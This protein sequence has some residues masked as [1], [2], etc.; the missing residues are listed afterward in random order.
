M[1]LE[2]LQ[3]F[4]A[5]FQIHTSTVL[6]VIDNTS[7]LF[8]VPLCDCLHLRIKTA[9]MKNSNSKRL[10]PHC[11]FMLLA[12]AL[13]FFSYSFFSCFVHIEETDGAIVLLWIFFL[14]LF[15]QVAFSNDVTL[16]WFYWYIILLLSLFNKRQ[17]KTQYLWSK[18]FSYLQL[19]CF[20]NL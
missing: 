12:V 14:S 9:F 3:S 18:M 1:C 10:L 11:A 19:I 15:L 7:D 13:K 6:P 5:Q 8:N 16:T 17:V 4:F 20:H 2:R